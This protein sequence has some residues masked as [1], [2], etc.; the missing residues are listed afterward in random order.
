MPGVA[1]VCVR[2]DW[3]RLLPHVKC[4][5]L[6]GEGRGVCDGC[7]GGMLL[8]EEKKDMIELAGLS[9]I[10]DVI[11]QIEWIGFGK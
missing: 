5:E 2:E 7:S 11:A 9:G 4:G 3:D 10:A 1:I 8:S 6:G